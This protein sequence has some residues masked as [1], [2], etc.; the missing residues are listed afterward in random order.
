MDVSP[1]PAWLQADPVRLA[2]VVSNLLNN[3]ARYTDP[4]GCIRVVA[5]AEG[6]AAVITVS[7]DG[8]GMAADRVAGVFDMFSQVDSRDIRAQEG[9]GIGLALVRNLV[10]MH[11]GGVSARSEGPGK[12]S[13]FEVRLPLLRSPQLQHDAVPAS[14]QPIHQR[15]LVVDD[16]R[17]A[18]DSLAAL[19]GLAGATVE[20]AYDGPQALQVA[21][22]FRPKVAVLDLGMPGMNGLDLARRL[23]EGDTDDECTLIALTGWGQASDRELTRSAG[24]SHHL[25]KPVD[26]DAMQSLLAS[27][28]A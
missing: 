14:K 7:D 23:R 13:E 8:M 16:N 2:Q 26:F 28:P 1:E 5:H 17:D 27:L 19:L 25:T 21:E 11:G 24:F 15:I 18:A 22:R 4:G 20:V 6:D 12:G 10:E 3:A 9:L